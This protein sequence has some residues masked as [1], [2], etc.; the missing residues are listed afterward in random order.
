M[1][2]LVWAVVLVL[3]HVQ[4]LHCRTIVVGVL[5]IIETSLIVLAV[6]LWMEPPDVALMPLDTVWDTVRDTVRDTVTRTLDKF[7]L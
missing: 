6:R 3:V 2:L 4:F 7:E 1:W 5:K